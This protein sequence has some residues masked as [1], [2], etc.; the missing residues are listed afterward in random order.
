MMA[1]S[2]ITKTTPTPNAMD[3]SRAVRGQATQEEEDLE[4]AIRESLTLE[5][6]QQM[7]VRSTEDEQVEQAI[8]SSKA[9][10]I[11]Q[12]YDHIQDEE[13]IVQALVNSNTPSKDEENL[14]TTILLSSLDQKMTL[15]GKLIMAT[16]QS[17][18]V[19]STLAHPKQ[20]MVISTNLSNEQSSCTTETMFRH[21]NLNIPTELTN[22]N[23]DGSCLL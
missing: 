6:A 13:N 18:Q 14:A 5:Y 15:E 22:T 10:L 12:T 7:S 2:M 4:T 8:Q 23:P 11:I 3:Y 1:T 21:L 20:I 16:E 9:D 17:L 19:S